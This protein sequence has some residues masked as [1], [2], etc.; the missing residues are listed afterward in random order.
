MKFF[1]LKNK[2]SIKYV[3]PPNGRGFIS[4]LL[5]R[6]VFRPNNTPFKFVF[7]TKGLESVEKIIF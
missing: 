7:T 5:K 2:R 3:L 1:S 4:I 6:I